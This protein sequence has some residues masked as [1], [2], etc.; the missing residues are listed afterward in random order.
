M[1]QLLLSENV[2]LMHESDDEDMLAN[3]EEVNNYKGM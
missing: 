1:A 3:A 2:P